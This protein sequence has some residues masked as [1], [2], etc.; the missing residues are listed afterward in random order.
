MSIPYRETV[1]LSERHYSG[2]ETAAMSDLLISVKHLQANIATVAEKHG[3][4]ITQLYTLHAIADEHRT[5]GKMAQ[6]IRCDAS[7]VTGI[8]DRLVSMGLVIR[9]EDAK[10]R[11]I[12]TV[13]LTPDGDSL[14]RRIMN[15][16]PG[17]LGYSR[18]TQQEIGEL[19]RIL[20]K[21]V[22]GSFECVQ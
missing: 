4:T 15:A 18:I 10:D 5:M 2:V 3:L 12:K 11:R 17:S 6:A 7:N 20:L 22:G 14:L 8:I 19:R 9:Q 13:Q 1:G 21:L 16:M